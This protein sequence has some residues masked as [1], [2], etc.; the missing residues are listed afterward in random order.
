MSVEQQI[1]ALTSA[2]TALLD[3]VLERKQVLDAAQGA[4]S[5]SADA[6]AISESAAA[7]S[8][9]LAGASAQTAA[10]AVYRQLTD[11]KAQ[12]ETARD[13]A[14]AGLGAA[15]NSQALAELL[16]AIVYA[17]DLAGQAVREIVRVDA[18]VKTYDSSIEAIAYVLTVALD[19][20]G[21]TARAVSG[22]EVLLRAGA[23]LPPLAPVGDRDTGLGFPAAD[24]IA[25]LAA[26]LER[27]RVTADGRVGI[28]TTAPSGLLDVND[29]KIR[30]R[31][32][33]T[34]AS[35]SAPG[36]PGELAWDGAFIYVCVAANTWRRAPHSTW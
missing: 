12:T 35:A 10:D 23:G 18:G 21:V 20:A 36:N 29:N 7:G 1:A 2:T 15:D 31:V 17:T 34:P 28:G 30:V 27:V 13:Q 16:G 14:L 11:I 26:G 4:A 19:L 8:A 22:G 25:L 6:A 3:A 5:A 9:A 24:T 32:A 33:Q